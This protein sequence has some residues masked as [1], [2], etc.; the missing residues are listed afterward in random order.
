MMLVNK[1]NR[2]HEEEFMKLVKRSK[3][4]QIVFFSF[5]SGCSA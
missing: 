5:F 2:I 3:R 1:G 4:G